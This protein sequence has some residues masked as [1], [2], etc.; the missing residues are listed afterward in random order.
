[1]ARIAYYHQ[2]CGIW[3]SEP[4]MRCHLCE[5]YCKVGIEDPEEKSPYHQRK[6]ALEEFEI[7]H[8]YQD[9]DLEDQ[10]LLVSFTYPCYLHVNTDELHEAL[11][12][13]RGIKWN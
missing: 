4:D 6:S 2:P 9:L 12:K 7:M 10:E 11:F 1:M 5:C 3:I 8:E 13:F